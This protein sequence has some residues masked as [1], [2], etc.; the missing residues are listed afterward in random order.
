MLNT[1]NLRMAAR[2]GAFGHVN[3]DLRPLI[4]LGVEYYS[5]VWHLWL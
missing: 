5:F 2:Y 4:V 1:H 3:V